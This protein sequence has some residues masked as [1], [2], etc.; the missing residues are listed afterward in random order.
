MR[1]LMLCSLTVLLVGCATTAE[2]SARVQREVEEMI[3]IYG[4][5]CEKLGYAGGSDPWRDCV[6]RLDRK[7]NLERAYRYPMTT[8]CFANRG[9]FNCNAF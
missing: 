3:Q 6:L 7:D 5:A 1:K 4:P 9:Y 8:T 2:R